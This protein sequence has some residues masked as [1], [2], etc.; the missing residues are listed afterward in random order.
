MSFKQIK[1]KYLL[2]VYDVCWLEERYKQ[3]KES[4]DFL[5]EGGVL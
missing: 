4:L 1:G 2:K 5:F 3:L